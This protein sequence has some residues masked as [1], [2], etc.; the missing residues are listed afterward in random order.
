MSITKELV[1]SILE[2]FDQLIND[3]DEIGYGHIL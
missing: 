1:N 3:L 2:D